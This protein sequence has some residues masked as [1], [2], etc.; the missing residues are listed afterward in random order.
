MNKISCGLIAILILCGAS[1]FGGT[2]WEKKM[3]PPV[4][5]TQFIE[6]K[7]EAK[8]IKVPVREDTEDLWIRAN[9]PITISLT[10]DEPNLHVLASDTYKQATADYQA[11]LR[12]QSRMPYIVGGAAVALVAVYG[13]H[14]A[15]HG[16]TF[17]FGHGVKF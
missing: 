2:R 4:T 7:Q 12:T 14:R 3:H 17:S 6:V 9:T 13:V 10:Y 11:Q 15:R 16:K 1:F 5:I 8:I